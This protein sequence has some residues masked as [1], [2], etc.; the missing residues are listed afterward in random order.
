MF[1]ATA[2]IEHFPYIGIFLLLVLGDI[3]LP[4]PEDGTLILSG[5]LIAQKVTKL[6][7][8]LLVVYSGL[9]LTDFSLYWVGKKYGR[10]VVEHKRFRRIISAEKLSRLEEKFK[11]WGIFAVFVGRHFLGI[12][13]Q[14]FLAAGV[15]KMSALK[16]LMADAASAILTITLMV[17]I[18][19]LGGNSIQILQKD[20]K[21]IEHIGILILA[22]SFTGWM[23]YKYFRIRK[24]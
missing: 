5:F 20:V 7:P 16:F 17:G 6:L 19:F 8:T 22:I 13:A 18:G 10:R 12:R 14:I 24:I 11:K 4:F 9:L 23:I 21:R 3:G 15:M 2:F 1:E